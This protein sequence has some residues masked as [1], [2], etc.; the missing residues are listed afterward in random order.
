MIR[1]LQPGINTRQGW[2]IDIFTDDELH[3]IHMATLDVLSNY[4]VKVYNREALEI[5][6][7]AG[8]QVSSE[9]NHVRIPAYLVEDAIR[10]ALPNWEC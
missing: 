3:E 7:G 8:A 5:F 4:G 10:S 6:D 2:G 1:G 9:R